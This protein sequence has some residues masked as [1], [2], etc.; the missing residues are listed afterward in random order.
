M[1]A[2]HKEGSGHPEKYRRPSGRS[3]EEAAED[4]GGRGLRYSQSVL[5]GGTDPW[6]SSRPDFLGLGGV[7]YWECHG[8]PDP[9][10]FHNRGSPGMLEGKRGPK[11]I[12][13]RQGPLHLTS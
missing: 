8:P 11:N 2:G 12:A 7:S 1:P 13:C 3:C 10:T 9:G 6:N 4:Q 5:L